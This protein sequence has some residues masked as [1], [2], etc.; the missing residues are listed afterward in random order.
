MIDPLAHTEELTVADVDID[1]LGHVNNAV[2]LRWVDDCCRAHVER[3]GMPLSLMRELGVLP[4]V[5]RHLATYR[6]SARAGDRLSVSTK[7]VRV[8]GALATRHNEVR[9]LDTHELLVEVDT[10]WVWIDI[11]SGKPKAPPARIM[12][13]FGLAAGERV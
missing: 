6:S 1:E 4:V 13:A 8:R 2:Y 7:V 3:L 10:D 5:R 9:L 12:A 11:G